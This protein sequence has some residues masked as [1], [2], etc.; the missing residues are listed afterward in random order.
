MT[1]SRFVLAA[2]IGTLALLQAAPARACWEAACQD[3]HAMGTTP[4]RTP[5]EALLRAQEYRRIAYACDAEGSFSVADYV[6]RA[7]SFGDFM[8]RLLDWPK[9]EASAW[10]MK[11]WA[12]VAHT[13]VRSIEREYNVSTESTVDSTL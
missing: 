13:A 9:A 4:I 8:H 2:M 10:R 6:F 3:P 7:R 5:S 1:R 11:S 12:H